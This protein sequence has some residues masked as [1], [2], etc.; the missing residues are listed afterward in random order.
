MV[1]GTQDIVTVCKYN[2]AQKGTITVSKKGEV[3]SHA[4]ESD[5]MY[6]PQYEVQGQPGA[7][8]DIIA[9]EDIVTP[10]GVVHAKAGELVATLTT[11][12]DGTATSEPLYLGRY[13]VS[14]R[15]APAGMVLDSEPKEVTLAYAGQEV[16]VTTAEV[17]FVNERQ[18]VEISLKSCWNRMRPSPSG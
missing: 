8:Y 13:Q 15:T 11:G 1:D 16:S 17:G 6:Q 18:K 10:D 5:G 2:A 9:L 7:V 14:E 4:A 12:S 3:F